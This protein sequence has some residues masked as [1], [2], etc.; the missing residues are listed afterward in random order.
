MA[1][2]TRAFFEQSACVQQT[3]M[4]GNFHRA[5]AATIIACAD[6]AEDDG[7]NNFEPPALRDARCRLLATTIAYHMTQGAAFGG[8]CVEGRLSRFKFF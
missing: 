8:S 5:I 7:G 2:A 3:I 6:C 4:E 1:V